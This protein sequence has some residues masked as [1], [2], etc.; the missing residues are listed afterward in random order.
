MSL[1]TE[2]SADEVVQLKPF[3]E[4]TVLVGTILVLCC[5]VLF[6]F[7]RID[8]LQDGVDFSIC[9]LSNRQRVGLTVGASSSYIA[10]YTEEGEVNWHFA[11]YD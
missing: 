9:D 1:P 7:A 2:K 10:R 8:F 6:R 5:L 11:F 3:T 4:R